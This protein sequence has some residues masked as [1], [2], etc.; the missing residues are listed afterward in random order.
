MV[1]AA[2][3][4]ADTAVEAGMGAEAGMAEAGTAEAGTAA[5]TGA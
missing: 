1:A 3:A 2:M 4:A 5:G